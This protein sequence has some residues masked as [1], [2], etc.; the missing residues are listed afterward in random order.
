MPICPSAMEMTR[1]IETTHVHTFRHN[2]CSNLIENGIC[3]YMYIKKMG[4]QICRPD[5]RCASYN[6]C[7]LTRSLRDSLIP[8]GLTHTTTRFP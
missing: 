7:T 1:L 2:V 5:Y 8:V 6:L 3:K 4:C